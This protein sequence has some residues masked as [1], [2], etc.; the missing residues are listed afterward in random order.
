MRKRIKIIILCIFLT[1]VLSISF[2]ISNAN[3]DSAMAISEKSEAYKQWEELSEQEKENSIEPTYYNIKLEDSVKRSTLNSL[4]ESSNSVDSKYNLR[5]SLNNIKTKNQMHTGSCWAF[6]YSSV[7]ETT[8]AN[9]YKKSMPEYSPMHID[10]K[11][12]EIFNRNVGTGGSFLM[13]LA[14]GASENGPV[15]E[16]DFPFESV[17]DE[18]KNSKDNYYLSSLD[19]VNLNKT[20]QAKV[21]DATIFAS[22]YKNYNSTSNTVTYQDSNKLIGANKYSDD[23]VNAMRELVKKH[24]KEDGAVIASFYADSL[25]GVTTDGIY[26]SIFYNNEN[27]AYYYRNIL[28]PNHAVTI[29]GWDD[30]FKKENFNSNYQPVHDGAYIVLNSWGTNFGDSGYFYV[31]YDDAS[32]EQLV[33]GVDTMSERDEDTVLY[34]YDP[35]GMS[36][37]ITYNKSLSNAYAANVYTR[38]GNSSKYEYLSEVGVFMGKTEGVEIYV[39]SADDD[40]SKAIKVAEYTGSNAL[41]C[42]YHTLKFSPMLLTGEKFVVAVKYI[43]QEGSAIPIECNLYE[44]GLITEA[45]DVYNKAKA[46]SGESFISTDGTTWQDLANYKVGT[47]TLKDT[48]ACIKAMSTYSDTLLQIAVESVSLDKSNLTLEVGDTNTLSAT[49]NPVNA[50]NRNLSWKSSDE[51]VVTVSTSGVVTAKKIG[52]ATITVTTEDGNKT[53][54]CNISVTQKTNKA[55]DIYKDNGNIQS[56]SGV[57]TIGGT[58]TTVSNKIL[59]NTGKATIIIV[60]IVSLIA[61]IIFIRYRK[62]K[63]IK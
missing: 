40:I 29:V 59:P 57:T 32:I 62:L 7:L 26:T 51:S 63:D 1:V 55:D 22:I 2:N 27:K 20:V 9:K 35:L 39:N 10:Y 25:A 44:S 3:D 17:Y 43:N 18:T 38:K 37:Q 45:N 54:T 33:C 58:D 34:D 56:T 52:T 30:D 48:N 8:M 61:I 6:A 4:L 13:A 15:N 50:T 16:S 46:N 11:T 12:A 24:I 47:N 36:T 21:K 41:E 23:Q 49:I 28:S 5:T 42:G 53:A 14:Y 60:G 31:S 19:S